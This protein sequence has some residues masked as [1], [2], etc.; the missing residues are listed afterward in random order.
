[1]KYQLYNVCVLLFHIDIDEI[2]GFFFLSLKID[3]LVARI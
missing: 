3:F 1:M 2:Q